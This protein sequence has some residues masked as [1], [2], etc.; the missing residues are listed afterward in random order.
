MITSN[1]LARTDIVLATVVLVTVISLTLYSLARLSRRF[2]MPWERA[3]G[4]HL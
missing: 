4:L 2:L 1:A 3:T